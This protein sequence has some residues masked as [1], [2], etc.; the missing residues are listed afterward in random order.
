M[1]SFGQ[2]SA[3]RRSPFISPGDTCCSPSANVTPQHASTLGLR[4]SPAPCHSP[5]AGAGTAR[6]FTRPGAAAPI[7]G[8]APGSPPPPFCPPP[9]PL[10]RSLLSPGGAGPAARSRRPTPQR[11][12]QPSGALR[13]GGAR[14]GAPPRRPQG[15][16]APPGA[17]SRRGRRRGGGGGARRGFLTLPLRPG[18][19]ARRRVE[20]GGSLGE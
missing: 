7:S 6:H 20:R 3:R 10:P 5:P 12:L 1:K 2:C 8:P 11:R 16:A 9:A 17:G 14:R 4:R 15:S 13:G 18:T 19:D